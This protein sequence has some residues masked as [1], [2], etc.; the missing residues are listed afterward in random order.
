MSSPEIAPPVTGYGAETEYEPE[1]EPDLEEETADYEPVGAFTTPPPVTEF[2]QEA[3]DAAAATTAP[4]SRR[5]IVWDIAASCLVMLFGIAV[6]LGLTA[7]TVL[8]I[9]GRD[10][11]AAPTCDFYQYTLGWTLALIGPSI[12]WFPS[13][14]VAIV[15]MVKRRISFWVPLVSL[16]LAVLLWW[17]GIALMFANL[18]G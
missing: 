3:D 10:Q 14:I 9:F 18:L 4:A 1:L 17:A 5:L 2:T 13:V 12:A 16:A 8:Q 6:I 7:H 11:C 15:L